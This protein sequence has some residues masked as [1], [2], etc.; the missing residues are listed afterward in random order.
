MTHNLLDYG[1]Q[2]SPNSRMT[3]H[4]IIVMMLYLTLQT[5]NGAVQIVDSCFQL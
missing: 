5:S 2:F 3:C 4:T 1:I